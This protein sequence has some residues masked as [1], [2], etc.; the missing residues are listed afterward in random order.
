M[1]LWLRYDSAAR[2]GWFLFTAQVDLFQFRLE[3]FRISPAM[4]FISS[5][6]AALFRILAAFFLFRHIPLEHLWKY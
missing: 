6:G 2:F 1:D 5:G 4:G 3:S